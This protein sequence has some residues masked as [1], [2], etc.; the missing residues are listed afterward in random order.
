MRARRGT[1]APPAA[2]RHGRGGT[3]C[4][5]SRRSSAPMSG[6][7]AVS[8]ASISANAI[9][10]VNASLCSIACTPATLS[11]TARAPSS[12]ASAPGAARVIAASR[13]AEVDAASPGSSAGCR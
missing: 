8:A 12:E 13:R 5:C 1:P 4:S 11:A 9:C 2:A 3:S 6:N 7:S 10:V